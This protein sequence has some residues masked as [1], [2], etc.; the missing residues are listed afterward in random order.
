MS[1]GFVDRLVTLLG[2]KTDNSGL[3]QYQAGMKSVT[4]SVKRL[5][6]QTRTSAKVSER[7]LGDSFRR[8]VRKIRV[9]LKLASRAIKN[10]R[11]ANEEQIKKVSKA[12]DRLKTRGASLVSFFKRLVQVVVVS[13]GA[14]LGFMGITNAATTKV[15]AL[16]KSVGVTTDFLGALGSI[17]KPL[18]MDFEN[19]ADLV[20]EMNNKMGESKGM[21]EQISGVK[22]S[23]HILGL[24]YGRIKQ[25]APEEQFM[26]IMES[27]KKLSDQQAAVSAVDMLMGG[28]ANKILGFLRSQNDEFSTMLKHRASL[29]MSDKK[30]VDQAVLFTGVFNKTGVV[31]SS[32]KTQ[33]FGLI[34]G[35]LTPLLIKF[36]EWAYAN[37]DL[38]KTKVAEY[39]EKI[40]SKIEAMTKWVV[41]ILPK[42]GRFIDLMGGF[43]GILTKVKIALGLIAFVKITGFVVALSQAFNALYVAALTLVPVIQYIGAGVAALSA[44]VLIVAAAIGVLAYSLYDLYQWFTTGKSVLGSFGE[45]V[46]GVVYEQ[47]QNITKWFK[48]LPDKIVGFIKSSIPRIK[49]ALKDVLSYST[50]DFSRDWL[51]GLGIGTNDNEGVDPMR[52]V[53]KSVVNNSKKTSKSVKIDNKVTVQATTNASPKEIAGSVT[54]ELQKVFARVA[55]QEGLTD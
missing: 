6:T 11:T 43:E 38:I 10:W 8:G 9:S 34:G 50:S 35:S 21:S 31:V 16:A 45:Y 53:S 29:S 44:P 17:M 26:T 39:A 7:T 27:A 18:G 1:N 41:K 15:D 24:E 55:S 48:E 49:A 40:A 14:F 32:L 52:G 33:F 3:N 37:K 46:G 28:E 36:N 12:F 25:M 42:I 51:S 19:V 5:G 47:V 4:N 54:S 20:E 22:D 13:G 2:Y 30:G 23:L